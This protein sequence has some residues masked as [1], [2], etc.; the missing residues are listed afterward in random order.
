ERTRLPLLQRKDIRRRFDLQ[1]V[2]LGVE[3]ELNLLFAKTFDIEGF[4]ATSVKKLYDAI[5][6]R[7]EI[8]LNRFLFGLGIRHVG[9]V[10]AK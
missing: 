10:N 1:A 3:E 8:A 9:E 5:N 7:R 4:G 6:D 2:V